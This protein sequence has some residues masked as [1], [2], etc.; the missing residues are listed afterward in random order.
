MKTPSFLIAAASSC[1][2]TCCSRASSGEAPL[3]AQGR[4]AGVETEHRA[5][6][7]AA[8]PATPSPAACARSSTASW[9]DW[10]ATAAPAPTATCRRTSSSCRRPAPRRGSSSCS[11]GAGVNPDADDPL[12]RPIDADDFR[13]NGDN[14]S[15]FSNLRQNGLVRI[16]FPLPPNIRLIDPATNAPSAETFVDVWRSVPTVN[17]VALTGPD[18]GESVAARPERRRRLPAGRARRDAA[19][20]GARRAHQSRAGPGRAAAAAARRP[21]RRSSACCS[22]TIAC[23]RLPTPSRDGH[24]AVAGSRS[25]ARPRSSSRARSCSSAPARQCHGGPGQSTPQAAGRS[26]SRH[27]EPVSAARRHGDAGPLRVRAVP[28]ATR[29][30]RPDLRDHALAE[31]R[32]RCAA[33]APIPAARC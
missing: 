5:T 14:A 2:A 16:T 12:F 9:M 23:A 25:A 8:S 10:A 4:H 30:Q 15:D 32:A 13:I 20:A 24:D 7:A 6:T 27:L 19:G 22:R 18:D 3:L 17:D 31:R 1:S 26:L 11:C 21:G 29:A 28:A 33:R